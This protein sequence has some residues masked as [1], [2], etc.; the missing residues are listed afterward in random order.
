MSAQTTSGEYASVCSYLGLADDA[1]SHATYPTEAHRCYRLPNPTRIAAN[2]QES[3][4]LGAEHVNCPVFQG[5]G[6]PRPAAAG[7]TPMATSAR[8]AAAPGATQ[9][10]ELRSKGPSPFASGGRATAPGPARPGAANRTTGG[11]PR[12]P[13]NPNGPRPRAGGVS[14]P[15]ITIALFALAIVVVAIA[16]AIQQMAGGGDDGNT[17][18]N[19]V[20]ANATNTVIA[21]TRAAGAISTTPAPGTTPTTRTP[22]S[23]VTPGAGTPVVGTPGAAAK[24]HTVASGENCTGIADSAGITLAQFYALNPEVNNPACNN[25]NVG[26]VVKTAP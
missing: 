18:A 23:S 22:G 11:A 19:Q 6:V 4:C 14:M 24:T 9:T 16:I 2:H 13:G 8:P 12:R 5:E 10:G 20:G 26:Q 1:D 25:L 21:Q 3:F 7:A 15:V 17:P